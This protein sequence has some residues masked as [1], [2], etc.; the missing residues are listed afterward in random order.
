MS[1]GPDAAP[2]M[3]TPDNAVSTGRNF[4]CASFKKPLV[5]VDNLRTFA[6]SAVPLLGTIP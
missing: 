4:G 5:S 2:A 3:N 6:I 1:L